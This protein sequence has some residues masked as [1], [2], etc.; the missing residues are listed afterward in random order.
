MQIESDVISTDYIYTNNIGTVS[1]KVI[2]GESFLVRYLIRGENNYYI[3]I[4]TFDV[5]RSEIN[6]ITEVRR[7]LETIYR[8]N[9][10]K[11]PNRIMKWGYS[12]VKFSKDK[13]YLRDL[14]CE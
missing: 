3:N 9:K 8:G 13:I 10:K 5:V 2:N 6:P 11:Y 7:Y 12:A 4:M 1:I 14:I